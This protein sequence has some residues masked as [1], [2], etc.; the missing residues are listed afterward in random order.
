MLGIP[1]LIL[2]I[3]SGQAWHFSLLVFIVTAISLGEY[4][5]IA[6]PH[7]PKERILG[8][9][10]GILISFS[11]VIPGLPEPGLW[12]SGVMVAAFS[13]YLFFGGTLEERYRHLGWTLLGILYIGYLVPHFILL[14]RSLYGR[15][16][17]FFVLLVVMAGDTSA[18]IVGSYLGKK[19]LAPEISPG[20]T[21]EGAVGSLGASA[22]A[23]V[24]GGS[25]FLPDISWL[26]MLLF[27]S[28]LGILGQLGD[29]FESWIKRVFCVKDSSALLPG[30]GGLLDRMDSLIFPVVLATYYQRL[31]HP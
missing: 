6:F 22:V 3:R 11:I 16:W 30:H 31:L 29:L 27:S 26:E 18:Y 5:S 24:L 4:F 15:E 9:L 8:I 7:G 19:R 10:F 25:F 12:L 2:I 14:Y 23:G 20:K 17:V 13:T 1:L 28:V 21:V